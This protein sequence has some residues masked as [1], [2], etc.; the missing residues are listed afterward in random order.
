MK[1][2]CTESYTFVN[3]KYMKWGVEFPKDKMAIF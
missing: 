1:A 3:F 2:E